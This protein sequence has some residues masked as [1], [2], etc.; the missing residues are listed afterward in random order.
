MAA[1]VEYMYAHGKAQ[2]NGCRK[3]GGRQMDLFVN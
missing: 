1:A 2:R 3:R